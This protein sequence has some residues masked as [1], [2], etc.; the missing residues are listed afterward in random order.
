MSRCAHCGAETLEGRSLCTHHGS[1]CEDDW[2]TVNRI[3]CD[4]VHRG[5]VSSTPPKPLGSEVEVFF[6][7]TVEATLGE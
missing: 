7:T 4:F 1:R 2:A 3:M 5:I 6:G